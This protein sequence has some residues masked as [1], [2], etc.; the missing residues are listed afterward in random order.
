MSLFQNLNLSE[1][2]FAQYVAE[3]EPNID[4][5]FVKAPYF[6]TIDQRSQK[7]QSFILFGARG[8]GKSATRLAI[9]KESWAAISKGETRPL[10]VTLDDFSNILRNGLEK[11]TTRD[12]LIELGYLTSEAILVWLSALSDETRAQII[13]NLSTDEKRTALTVIDK[14]YLNR[15]EGTRQVTA[16]QASRLLDQAWTSKTAIWT[17]K[18]WGAIVSLIS[19]IANSISQTFAETEVDYTP[20]LIQLLTSEESDP[21]NYA[22]GLLDHFIDFAKSFG[23][24][25]ITILIDK[26]DET[27]FTSNSATASAKL[28]YPILVNIQ[29]LEIEDFGW[30][31]FLWDSLYKDY[32]GEKL[33]VR[34]DKIANAHINWPKQSL[35]EIITQRLYYFSNSHIQKVDDIFVESAAQLIEDSIDIAM[36]SPRELIRI[37]DTIFRENEEQAP[38]AKKLTAAHTQLALDKYCTEATKR[39]FD[40]QQLQQITKL[41]KTV[42]IN[43]DVQTTFRINTQSAKSRIDGWIDSGIATLSGSRP[44]EGGAGGKPANEYSVID[45]RIRR[46]ID[47]NIFLGADYTSIEE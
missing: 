36:N 37:F 46:L 29:L 43:K 4:Q 7:S 22:R 10:T 33:K 32:N 41:G 11:V 13:N 31:F 3:N 47:K 30:I 21:T 40:K 23:F 1:N 5:Y 27:E 25:G 34:L 15:P 12:F 6:K 18:K 9:Y 17:Q 26:A 45:A 14:F 35:Q 2:P 44:A 39:I 20:S 8:A 42:F 16:R 28:L 19:G 38:S 24:S